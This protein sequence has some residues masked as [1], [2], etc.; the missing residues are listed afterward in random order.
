MLDRLEQTSLALA[1]GLAAA[2]LL[3]LIGF[4][5]MTLADGLSRPLFDTSLEIVG[6]LGSLAVAVA[7]ACCVPLAFL[8][9]NHITIKFA[10]ACLGARGSR[11]LDV[12]AAVLVNVVAILIARQLFVFAG[13]SARAGDSTVMLEVPVAPFW[14]IVAT[15]IALAAA[16]QA[17]VVAKEI[18]RFFGADGDSWRP[19]TMVADPRRRARRTVRWGR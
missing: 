1:R 7:V 18:A 15:L 9:R 16:A 13:Q 19:P 12:G 10:G 3:I 2:G 4:A 8:Q 11:I 5:V 17:L 6:D 14:Y